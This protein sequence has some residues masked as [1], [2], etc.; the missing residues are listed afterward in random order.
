MTSAEIHE[1]VKNLVSNFN[2]ESSIYNLLRAHGIYRAFTTRLQ[3]SIL[4]NILKK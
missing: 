2:T 1:K 3:K 4:R